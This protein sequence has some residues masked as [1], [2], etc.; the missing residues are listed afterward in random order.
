MF[1]FQHNYIYNIYIYIYCMWYTVK[2][3]KIS[4]SPMLNA[5]RIFVDIYQNKGVSVYTV[6][7]FRLCQ[8]ISDYIVITVCKLW[9]E[10]AHFCV[11][12]WG[13]WS[14]TALLVNLLHMYHM[15]SSSVHINLYKLKAWFFQTCL[16]FFQHVVVEI[17]SST[18]RRRCLRFYLPRPWMTMSGIRPLAK[19]CQVGHVGIKGGV[20]ETSPTLLRQM[21]NILGLLY[22]SVYTPFDL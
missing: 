6:G 3:W 12:M 5:A 10:R 17:P 13:M 7:I 22:K 14:A 15:F 21:N 8:I 9:F 1:F 20:R 11:E 4:S 16:V 2:S 19:H 18:A